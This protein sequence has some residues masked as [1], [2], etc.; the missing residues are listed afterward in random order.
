MMIPTPDAQ[1]AAAMSE[2]L[3]DV[4]GWSQLSASLARWLVSV[5]GK[6]PARLWVESVFSNMEGRQ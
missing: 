1:V 5:K 2:L 3:R 4:G 6:A